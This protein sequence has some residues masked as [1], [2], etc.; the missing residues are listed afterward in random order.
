M[1]LNGLYNY[2]TFKLY[3]SSNINK[4]TRWTKEK[5]NAHKIFVE[6]LK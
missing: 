1:V 3:F 5:R 6:I 4:R 2:E